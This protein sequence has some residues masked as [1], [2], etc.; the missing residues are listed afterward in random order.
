MTLRTIDILSVVAVLTAV[1]CG[2]TEP[3]YGGGDFESSLT[4]NGRER[5]FRIHV[6][7]D[8]TPEQAVPLVIVFH[9]AGEDANDIR[10][11]SGFDAVADERGVLV[12]YLNGEEHVDQTW[13]FYGM[14]AYINGIDDTQFT[15]DVIDTLATT[16]NI[17][18]DRVYAAGF[19]NGGLFTQELGCELRGTLAAISSVAASLTSIVQ[20][21]CQED[22]VTPAV[23]IHGSED[24]IFPW[25]GRPGFMAPEEM[26]LLWADLS[27]CTSGPIVTDLPDVLDDGITVRRHDYTDCTLS[28]RISLYAVEGGGHAWPRTQEFSASE[29]MMDYFEEVS[30]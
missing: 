27:G 14:P 26:L 23:F 29:A 30:R 13:G 28:D 6:P 24:G 20:P 2:T 10:A 15:I 4:S 7:P 16:F 21:L 9:G 19:S 5:T 17:D 25:T 3:G 18:R 11:L 12:A 8:I 22:N 1:A